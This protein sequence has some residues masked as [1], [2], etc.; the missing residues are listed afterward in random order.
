[1]ATYRMR[2]GDHAEA[3]CAEELRAGMGCGRF[4]QG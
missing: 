4:K 2:F 1:M 3:V